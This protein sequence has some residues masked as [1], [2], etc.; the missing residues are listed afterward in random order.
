MPFGNDDSRPINHRFIRIPTLTHPESL[1]HPRPGPSTKDKQ[2][3]RTGHLVPKRFPSRV[4]PSHHPRPRIFRLNGRL[5]LFHL[6]PPFTFK[7]GGEEPALFSNSHTRGTRGRSNFGHTWCRGVG[8]TRLF[9]VF[10]QWIVRWH[11]DDTSRK[12]V[13]E[14]IARVVCSGR[15]PLCRRCGLI[16]RRP[17]IKVSSRHD[18]GGF[19][20]FGEDADNVRGTAPGEQSKRITSVSVSR[21]FL[22]K[23]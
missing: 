6:P 1:A 22:F 5:F 11:R 20:L 4:N 8:L 19:K 13:F 2:E 17:S 15:V 16:G 21:R 14:S 9:F 3:T 23:K 7:C 10:P 12:L 18:K